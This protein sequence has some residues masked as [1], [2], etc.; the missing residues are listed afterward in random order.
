VHRCS[1]PD[2]DDEGDGGLFSQS[3]TARAAAASSPRCERRWWQRP[4]L[5]GA[6]DDG[7]S[8][9]FSQARTA[10]V[11]AAS[12]P[13]QGW[14]WERGEGS[15]AVAVTGNQG[16]L[17]PIGTLRAGYPHVQATNQD[18]GSRLPTEGSSGAVTCPRGSSSRSWLGAT[19]CPHGSGSR[20]R[21]EAAPGPPRVPAARAPAPGSGK[22]WGR[23]VSPRLRAAPGPPRIPRLCK[24]PVS[25]QIS[26]GGPTIMI[27]IRAGAPVSS[28]ALRRK[29]CS[30]RLIKCK[31]DVWQTGC[32]GPLQHQA[33][34]RLW[35]TGLLQHGVSDV[36]HLSAAAM[37]LVTQQ[38]STVS[39]TGCSMAGDKNRLAH[40]V[41]DIIGY[42]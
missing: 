21:L 38:R 30:R 11:A 15:V 33:V 34:Q 1:S 16:P 27:S 25:K 35:A 13:R 4:L 7:G 6:N 8:S 42:S 2:A 23:H 37:G 41:E 40:I 10:T 29:A 22:L 39:K 5:P 32:S 36:G 12:S 20:F 26:S 3:W 17:Q 9:L 31:R 19:T 14:R 18:N 28:K 24:L